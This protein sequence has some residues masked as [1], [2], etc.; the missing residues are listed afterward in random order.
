[1]YEREKEIERKLESRYF[2]LKQNLVNNYLFQGGGGGGGKRIKDDKFQF[3][4]Y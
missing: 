1:M 2:I 3:L 4:R